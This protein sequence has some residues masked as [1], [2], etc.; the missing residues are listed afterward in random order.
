M[1]GSTGEDAFSSKTMSVSSVRMKSTTEEGKAL[2]APTSGGI[3]RAHYGS[4]CRMN[5]SVW[6][7]LQRKLA[8]SAAVQWPGRQAKPSMPP[9]L[10]HV[11]VRADRHTGR[12][13]LRCQY[14][15]AAFVALAAASGHE[16][17]LIDMFFCQS[18]VLLPH[19]ALQ[20]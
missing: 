5:V 1:Y 16:K 10:T 3:W 7:C 4:V 12:P 9:P 17:S 13:V 19:Q 14:A 11:R 6:L 20:C 8:Q 2:Q 15:P 18:Q